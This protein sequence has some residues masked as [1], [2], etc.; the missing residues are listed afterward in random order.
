MNFLILHFSDRFHPLTLPSPH[1]GIL[2]KG[3]ILIPCHAA[4]HILLFS[5]SHHLCA[6]FWTI[7]TSFVH[8]SGVMFGVTARAEWQPEHKRRIPYRVILL[9]AVVI[10][11]RICRSGDDD[12]YFILCERIIMFL[13][14]EGG[15]MRLKWNGP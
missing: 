11:I 9:L 13:L 8:F 2:R 12:M 5:C 6:I 3:T 4:H 1:F 10:L 7:I 14:W 15:M